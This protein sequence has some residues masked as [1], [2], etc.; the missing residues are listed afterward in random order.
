MMAT[1]L[2][3]S[4]H[5]MAIEFGTVKGMMADELGILYRITVTRKAG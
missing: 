4:I 5:L 2:G 3:A 1:E